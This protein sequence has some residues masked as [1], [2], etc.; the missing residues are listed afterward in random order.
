[1]H[2]S[3]TESDAFG[4]RFV[5]AIANESM[6]FEAFHNQLID[7]KAD[8]CR[9]KVPVTHATFIEALQN[10]GYWVKL[11]NIN[12]F[13]KRTLPNSWPLDHLG[14][15]KAVQVT[16]LSDEALTIIDEIFEQKGWVNYN[17]L[18]GSLFLTH[19]KQ[20]DAFVSWVGS[21]TVDSG[22]FLWLLYYKGQAIGLY[23]GRAEDDDFY[24]DL[25]G[26][27]IANRG[28]GHSKAFYDFIIHHAISQGH[29]HF[30]TQ[31]GLA[32]LFSQRGSLSKDMFT[33]NA[34]LQFD[35]FP[36]FTMIERT[37]LEQTNQIADYSA[38]PLHTS[39]TTL[40]T[41]PASKLNVPKGA[42]HAKLFD[43][44]GAKLMAHSA[45]RLSNT[46]AIH[47]AVVHQ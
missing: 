45:P 35:V 29:K 7:I 4:L 25:N 32:N 41:V 31:I 8:L 17:T 24:G 19:Q 3:N 42:W 16:S 28:Q 44:S 26:L 18:P 20:K 1:M 37:A 23:S 47:Y 22:K 11:S 33:E 10:C 12:L 21:Y 6:S 15:Y 40:A 27:R 13:N 14:D 36:F 43:N 9:V 46:L 5:R 39:L 34:H 2:I 30:I 38:K